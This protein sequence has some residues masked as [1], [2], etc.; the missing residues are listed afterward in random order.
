MVFH[1][2][3]LLV[4]IQHVIFLDSYDVANIMFLLVVG[5]LIL[6]VAAVV[7]GSVVAIVVVVAI[8]AIAF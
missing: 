5:L 2:D 4:N 7:I 1:N 3:F 8:V 6:E